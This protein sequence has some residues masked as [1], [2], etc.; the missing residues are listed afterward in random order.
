VATD[1][2][3]SLAALR[4]LGAAAIALGRIKLELLALEWQDEKAR[5]AQLLLAA[6]VGALLAGFALI[7]LA[8]TVTV[9]LWDTPHR[10]LALIVTTG[11]LMAG[12]L[13]SVWRV[14]TLLKGASPLASTVREL[15]RDEATL[16]DG[17]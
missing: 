9:A 4:R 1:G 13:A 15:Q 6:T 2:V 3:G 8:V 7:A 17:A 11:L 14:I 12:A 16:R 10:M 5:I